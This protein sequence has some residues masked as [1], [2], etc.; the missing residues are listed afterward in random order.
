MTSASPSP[1]PPSNSLLN[2]PDG[3][4]QL[5]YPSTSAIPSEGQI[6]NQTAEV[7]REVVNSHSPTGTSI[8]DLPNPNMFD[9][10]GVG[11]DKVALE[12]QRD[13]HAARP[14]WRRASVTW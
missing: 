7:L 14:W 8:E 6:G 2:L 11:I 12:A 4:L 5:P 13:E 9:R 10:G 1:S 3:A